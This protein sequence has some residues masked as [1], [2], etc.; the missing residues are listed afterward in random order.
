M[1][2]TELAQIIRDAQARPWAALKYAKELLTP[3]VLAEC[4]K[5]EP[6]AALVYAKELLTP[7]R[8]RIPERRQT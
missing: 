1:T 3:E 5:A 8:G 2:Q 7:D 6:G 4:A